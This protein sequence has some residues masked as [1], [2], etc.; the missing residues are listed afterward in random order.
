MGA[1]VLG[2]LVGWL[3]E[4]LFYT[5]WVKAGDDSDC[6][7]VKAELEL[8][9]RQISSLQAQLVSVSDDSKGKGR[10]SSKAATKSS[11]QKSAKQSAKK[12]GIRPV[13][14][15]PQAPALGAR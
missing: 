11:A 5:F 10:S 15:A 4:W 1:F 14:L 13:P 8:K 7:A 12:K 6:S 3:A 2:V 9:N